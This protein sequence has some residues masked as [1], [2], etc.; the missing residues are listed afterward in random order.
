M[1]LETVAL[2]SDAG[3]RHLGTR[4]I[5]G[6]GEVWSAELRPAGMPSTITTLDLAH[7]ARAH[8]A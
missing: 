6:N 3:A 4:A 1:R 2:K 7:G 8:R 5:A